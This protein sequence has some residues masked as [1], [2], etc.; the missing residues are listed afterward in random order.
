MNSMNERKGKNR[1]IFIKGDESIG[2]FLRE[3]FP[4]PSDEEIATKKSKKQIEEKR[5]RGREY[6]FIPVREINIIPPYKITKENEKLATSYIEVMLKSLGLDFDLKTCVT[7]DDD[8]LAFID[9]K[10][11]SVQMEKFDSFYI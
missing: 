6:L 1:I 2:E 11:T 4:D 9:V 7:E 5:K 3:L 10:D 8:P